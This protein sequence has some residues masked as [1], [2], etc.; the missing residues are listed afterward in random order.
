MSAYDDIAAVRSLN[1][2]DID[3]LRNAQLKQALT[4]LINEDRRNEPSN[5]VL[6]QE[7]RSV[8]EAIAEVTSLKKE[9]QILSVRL[10]DA[11]KI[12]HNQQLFLEALDSKERRRSLVITGLSEDDDETGTTDSEKIRKVLDAVGYTENVDQ[13]VW[14]VKRL[15]QRNDRNIRPILIMVESQTQRDSIIRVAKNLMSA[16]GSLSRVYIKKDVHPAV[17]KEA[18]LLRRRKREEKEKT[19]NVGVNIGYD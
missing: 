14:T 3:K 19:E 5:V 17:R 4:T 7:L 18:A 16:E 2:N 8:K 9:V 15:G 10:D 12:I 6:L 1:A 13:A 11:Y